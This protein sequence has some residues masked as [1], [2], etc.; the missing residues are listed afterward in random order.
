MYSLFQHDLSLIFKNNLN[1]IYAFY[2]T[3][4]IHYNTISFICYIP[5]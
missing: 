4:L 5:L 2:I 3:F 1:T